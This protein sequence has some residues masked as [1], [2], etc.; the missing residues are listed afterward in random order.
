MEIISYSNYSEFK[1]LTKNFLNSNHI[2][3]SISDS[4]SPALK[5]FDSVVFFH[6]NE[7]KEN[8][9]EL[10]ELLSTQKYSTSIF[11]EGHR[12]NLNWKIA[13]AILLDIDDGETLQ[14]SIEILNRIQCS[15]IVIESKNHQKEK[16]GKTCDRF[17]ILIIPNVPITDANK[18]R[19]YALYFIDL[20]K[21]DK[22][23]KDLARYFN[24]T[25]N[26]QKVNKISFNKQFCEMFEI[27]VD[28]K[29][30][31]YDEGQ[32][33]IQGS[34]FKEKNPFIQTEA[35]E[36]YVKQ[37][38]NMYPQMIFSHYNE[39]N[40]SMN[41]HRNSQDKGPGVFVY[42]DSKMISDPTR[43]EFYPTVF[44]MN[45]F[46]QSQEVNQKKMEARIKEL[47]LEINKYKGD[48]YKIDIIKTNEGT[49]KSYAVCQ[50]IEKG[51]YFTANTIERLQEIEKTLHDLQKDYIVIYSNANLIYNTVLYNRGETENAKNI[52]EELTRRYDL[53]FKEIFSKTEKDE[54]QKFQEDFVTNATVNGSNS[55]YTKK[56]IIS[57]VKEELSKVQDD[58]DRSVLEDISI[59][60]FLMSHYS[61][62]MFESEKDQ[63]LEMYHAQIDAIKAQNKIYLMTTQKFFF[64]SN[65]ISTFS[66]HVRCFQDECLLDI[67]K[68][69]KIIDKMDKNYNI[70]AAL[71]YTTRNTMEQGDLFFNCDEQDKETIE[72]LQ[73]QNTEYF[74]AKSY[75]N[76]TTLLEKRE[77]DWYKKDNFHITILTTED[78]PCVILRDADIYDLSHKIHSPKLTFIGV[79][80]MNSSSKPEFILQGKDRLLFIKQLT[81][82]RFKIDGNMIIAN[83][84]NQKWNFVNSKGTNRFKNSLQEIEGSKKMAIILTFPHPEQINEKKGFY[85]EDLKELA[86]KS[87]EPFYEYL[88]SKACEQEMISRIIN[89]DLNQALGRVL[90]YRNT[91]K[92]SEVIVIMNFSLFS[93]IDTK[94]TT[95]NIFTYTGMYQSVKKQREF[96]EIWEYLQKTQLLHAHGKRLELD[97]QTKIAEKNKVMS[98]SWI[99][100]ILRKVEKL[101][102]DLIT[103]ARQHIFSKKCQINQLRCRFKAMYKYLLDNKISS[104]QYTKYCVEKFGLM[105][106]FEKK[107]AIF[108]EYAVSMLKN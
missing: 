43:G 85:L 31:L 20:L 70:K 10:I 55:E 50:L 87:N 27:N 93:Y 57:F 94:Y 106:I 21:C 52:A 3:F 5:T 29:N 89:D 39:S 54:R 24:P 4:E 9:K 38:N 33:P 16:N 13:S 32:I 73:N 15:Y 76:F 23:V 63:V 105:G 88:N 60:A 41:F 67:Y 95:E 77:I 42:S 74:I 28:M 64:M 66:E 19:A 92:I 72:Y 103:K 26:L 34:F 56:Q 25:P 102:N 100:Y 53:F 36:L 97:D 2:W 30:E 17:H 61:N 37:V 69:V 18:Y 83:A 84:I 71:A 48:T 104:P 90:G 79:E 91:D 22:A 86:K 44:T 59:R 40:S 58:D 82:D 51:M 6:K 49:G 68:S 8:N 101:S 11:K 78:L 12:T 107:N 35:Q 81:M 47:I 108:R 14:N 46:N 75:G 45:D 1:T 96:P 80:G 98:R 7:L 99:K 62:P 65:L